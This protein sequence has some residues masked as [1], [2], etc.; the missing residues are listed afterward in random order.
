MLLLSFVSDLVF[1][2]ANYLPL[3][4]LIHFSN[5]CRRL[6]YLFKSKLITAKL[7]YLL[8]HEYSLKGGD[9]SSALVNFCDQRLFNFVNDYNI[10]F[11]DELVVNSY[12][13]I[14]QY[15]LKY[16][17]FINFNPI[18]I[19]VVTSENYDVEHQ[20]NNSA[21]IKLATKIISLS[22]N[23][24]GKKL[25]LLLEPILSSIDYSCSVIKAL[26]FFNKIQALTMLFDLGYINK[27]FSTNLL[28][29]TLSPNGYEVDLNILKLL[30]KFCQFYQI[31]NFNDL[32]SILNCNS[33]VFIIKS[34]LELLNQMG[35]DI[36]DG[37]Q[38]F[39]IVEQIQ[40][41]EQAVDRM[42][43]EIIDDSALQQYLTNFI[44]DINSA[45]LQALFSVISSFTLQQLCVLLY[46]CEYLTNNVIDN[47]VKVLAN[48]T[49]STI[50]INTV[51]STCNYKLIIPI[52]KL[53]K[54][55]INYFIILFTKTNLDINI[56]QILYYLIQNNIINTIEQMMSLNFSFCYIYL[57]H[58]MG[59]GVGYELSN[60]LMLLANDKE[61]LNSVGIN[62]FDGTFD[63]YLSNIKQLS[64]LVV[65]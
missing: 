38:Y 52:H 30:I 32:F 53:Y 57:A 17:T 2:I 7:H 58:H 42:I 3:V 51:I 44:D 19:D 43:Q 49:P 6:R 28:L 65:K 31:N 10:I 4:D 59:L 61:L 23:V 5:S 45:Q 50:L 47:I 22:T 60:Q 18:D 9:A 14:A 12:S 26:I 8:N 27:Q 34:N 62:N 64:W 1:Y 29:T 25:L 39:Y 16:N 36:S 46:K 54:F 15:Y 48:H 37:H 33:N 20:C 56:L 55:S 63:S 13:F 21:N 24:D 35:F 40:P 41:I 11:S